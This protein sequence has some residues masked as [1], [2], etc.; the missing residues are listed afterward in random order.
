MITEECAPV[1]IR[2][3]SGHTWL[4][5]PVVTGVGSAEVAIQ[6]TEENIYI[7]IDSLGTL[8][9]FSIQS[10]PHSS[11]DRV[12]LIEQ[13]KEQIRQS[14]N[15]WT[16]GTFAMLNT[17]G[18]VKG[19]LVFSNDEV[20]IFVFDRF[21]YTPEV[22]YTTIVEENG[23]WLL[24]FESEPTFFD[25]V[26]VL[27]VHPL[28]NIVTVPR[29]NVPTKQDIRYHL[30]PEPPSFAELNKL[31]EMQ[32]QESVQSEQQ[33]LQQEANRLLKD[34]TTKARC[35]SWTPS[36]LDVNRRVGYQYSME[37]TTECEVVIE[38]IEVQH[39]RR[40]SGRLSVLGDAE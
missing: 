15:A 9:S 35:M 32:L 2:L 36:P 31:A 40:F 10:I 22:Q 19:A 5:V 7:P 29:D 8:W 33:W 17:E 1:D 34:L 13:A 21:W 27:R 4:D 24:Y 39:T 16:K 11:Q 14:A 6:V 28:Q 18:D 23:D 30:S 3:D 37:W 12:I 25:E 26:S 20:R 38:P